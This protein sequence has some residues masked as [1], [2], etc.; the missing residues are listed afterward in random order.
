[1]AESTPWAPRGG[2]GSI[3]FHDSL[4]LVCGYNLADVWCSGDVRSWTLVQAG[5]PWDAR[6]GQAAVAFHD[7]MWTMGGYDAIRSRFYNDVWWSTD[8]ANWAQAVQHADWADRHFPAGVVYQDKIWLAGGTPNY[9]SGFND[10]WYTT[11]LV[12]VEQ[13]ANNELGTT[14]GGACIVRGVLFL[15]ASGE[16][17]M[18]NSALVDI[19]G[20]RVIDLHPG[21]N[22]VSALSPGVYFYRQTAG[23]ASSVEAQVQTVRKVIIAR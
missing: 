19:S 17:R 1:M 5:V 20:R 7:T 4:W 13:V 9:S 10:V 21:A 2:Q 11:G 8:G 15:S 22:D 3:I 14:G 18:V 16:E 6:Y 23:F 12:G